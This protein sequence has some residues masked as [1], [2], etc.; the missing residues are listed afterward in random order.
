[1]NTQNTQFTELAACTSRNGGLLNPQHL[2]KLK[3]LL[4]V[5]ME[6]YERPLALH[7]RITVQDHED[8]QHNIIPYL[9]N[10]FARK[11]IQASFVKCV[12]NTEAENY[13]H[14]HLMFVVNGYAKHLTQ[15][16]ILELIHEAFFSMHR[17]GLIKSFKRNSKKVV[18]RYGEDWQDYE[19]PHMALNQE[20]YGE[21]LQWFSYS[22]KKRSKEWAL[23]QNKNPVTF[24]MPRP[25]GQKT[26]RGRKKAVHRVTQIGSIYSLRASVKRS[27]TGLFRGAR[28]GW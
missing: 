14:W 1:M 4:N 18:G 15:A 17:N 21:I 23:S 2:V 10:L 19:T 27:V 13:H 20:T 26:G 7:Y 12:E 3:A 16:E 8:T 24:S 28:Y 11:Q 22:L 25:L 5:S 6:V 9:Q